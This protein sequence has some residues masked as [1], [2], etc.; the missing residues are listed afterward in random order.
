LIWRPQDYQDTQLFEERLL[1]I[2]QQQR[3]KDLIEDK[4]TN[5]TTETETLL[6]QRWKR[7]MKLR[8]RMIT[9]LTSEWRRSRLPHDFL[10]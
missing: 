4:K 2:Q 6:K 5:Q 7:R 1:P 9:T 10:D 3:I 8:P